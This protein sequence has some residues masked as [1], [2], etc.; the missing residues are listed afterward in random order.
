M[1]R[2]QPGDIVRR[3]PGIVVRY[4][5]SQGSTVKYRVECEH[6]TRSNARSIRDAEEI[7]RDFF[8]GDCV[9]CAA[10]FVREAS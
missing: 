9:E 8:A 4:S 6:G 3:R 5:P 7:M 2:Y 1:S 10:R